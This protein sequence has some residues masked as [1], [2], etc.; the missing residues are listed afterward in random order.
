MSRRL[1][2]ATPR[3]IVPAALVTQMPSSPAL[4]TSTLSYPSPNRATIFS[5]G[6][7]ALST[8][9]EKRSLRAMIAW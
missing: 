2:S 8:S 9:R 3:A 1:V 6:A 7:S 4:S 5:S